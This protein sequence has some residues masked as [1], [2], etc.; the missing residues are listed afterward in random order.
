MAAGN[1]FSVRFEKD[2]PRW[3]TLA[4][5]AC[6]PFSILGALVCY[7]W[8]SE[9][10]D[11]NAGL[12]A[13]AL[14]CFC[15]NIL[16]NA[17][18]ITPDAGAA[19][20]GVTAAY[21]FW[22]WLSQPTWASAILAGIVL[23]LALLTKMTL[24]LLLG[25]WPVLWLLC[26]AC[27]LIVRRRSTREGEALAEP[28]LDV[29]SGSAGASPFQRRANNGSAGA[30]PSQYR[31]GW[32]CLVQLA[33]ILVLA[34][35]VLNAGYEFD[36]SFR[37]LGSYDFVSETLSGPRPKQDVPR[38]AGPGEWSR[39]RFRS[40]LLEGM[41]IPF[42]KDYVLGIDRAKFDFERGWSSYL[43]GEWS[44]HGWW[45]FYLYAAAIK[46]PL[47]TW[48]LGI[49]AV[50]VTVRYAAYREN[51]WD[52]FIMVAPGIALFTFVSAETGF[53]HHLRYVLPS[54]PF[55]IIWC[56]KV[57]RSVELGHRKIAAIAGGALVW[58]IGSSFYIYP[59]SHS[60]F[61]ELVAGPKNGY[62]HLEDSNTD[63]GQDLFLFKKWY[64]A[65]PEARPMRVEFDGTLTARIIEPTFD[66]PPFDKRSEEHGQVVS[67][68]SAGPLPGWYAISVNDL[69]SRGHDYDYFR[70]FE[71]VDWIGYS[72]PVYHITL[73]EC[74]RVRRKLGLPEVAE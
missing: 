29:S 24:V 23:G 65:H 32:M 55:A 68:D 19:A 53:S 6:I 59:H 22:K 28:N 20:L 43:R 15:P 8:A 16:A 7:R 49:L 33:T 25:V 9:L 21:T 12:V 2:F 11:A 71:P 40:T 1:H 52:T 27:D 54:F 70:E 67:P 39:N 74:N 34:L 5:W 44:D 63:W 56:S 60:Y 4:R 48:L 35:V 18:L 13:A 64:D 36:G 41:P 10:Y 50:V 37:L 30:S 38:V 31:R 66:P 51:C 69:I 62:L 73:E 47:S 58:S 45:Y 72:M 46:V 61:N 17:Q 26:A 3:L 42:P 57:A 14:W